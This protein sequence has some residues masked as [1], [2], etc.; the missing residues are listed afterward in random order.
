VNFRKEDIL[1]DPVHLHFMYF[2][3]FDPLEFTGHLTT[4]EKERLFSFNSVQR[5]KEFVVTR[6]LRHELFGFKHIHYN[7]HGAPYIEDEGFIS[8]S[9]TANMV[10]IALC[11]DFEIG[12]DLEKIDPKIHR[13]QD[14]FLTS[15]E[16]TVFDLT[17]TEEMIKVW[18]SKEALYKLAGRRGIHFQQ[19][20][21]VHKNDDQTWGGK[22]INLDH[23]L[24]V[25]LTLLK[26][27]ST[28]VSINNKRCEKK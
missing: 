26:V 21:Q 8:I 10:A 2:D 6:L 4:N 7:E 15:D 5:R 18:S 25:A 20:L 1:L 19:E 11:H 23:T 9:H 17:S 3:E 27:D 22:I 13:I 12:L 24:E 14:R 28:I 16:K